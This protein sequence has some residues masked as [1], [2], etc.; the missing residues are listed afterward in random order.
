M[1][2]LYYECLIKT[3]AMWLYQNLIYEAWLYYYQK[4]VLEESGYK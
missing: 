2:Q 4:N 1:K 3:L